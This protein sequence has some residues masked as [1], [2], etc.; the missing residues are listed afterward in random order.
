MGYGLEVYRANG[1]L[2]LK[3]GDTLTRFIDSFDV[4]VNS[5]G[6]KDYPNLSGQ[7]LI[8]SAREIGGGIGPP[9]LSVSGTTV[10]WSSQRSHSYDISSANITVIAVG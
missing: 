3:T 8:A 6:S 7:K 4:G 2:S 10:S 5:T 1:S 9:Y